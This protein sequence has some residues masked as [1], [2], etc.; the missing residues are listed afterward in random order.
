MRCAVRTGIDA[1]MRRYDLDPEIS[2]AD[3]VAGLLKGPE[4]RKYGEGGDYRYEARG[5]QARR[6]AHH[7]L[8]GDAALDE[9]VGELITETECMGAARKVRIEDDDPGELPPYGDQMPAEG[10]A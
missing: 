3:E 6:D 4:R 5:R 7:V 8:L 10:F 1:R 2:V 9:A